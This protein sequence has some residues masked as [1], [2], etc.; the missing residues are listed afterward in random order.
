SCSSC[1]FIVTVSFGLRT[2]AFSDISTLF[3]L[4]PLTRVYCDSH[5]ARHRPAATAFASLPLFPYTHSLIRF[6][7]DLHR[8]R[9]PATRPPRPPLTSSPRAQP[10]TRPTARR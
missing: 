6:L 1:S 9:A 2:S 4:P 7:S 8:P 5:G 10:T 3:S